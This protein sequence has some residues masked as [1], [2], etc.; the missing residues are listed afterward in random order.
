MIGRYLLI[1]CLP[2]CHLMSLYGF[3]NSMASK[4]PIALQISGS[5]WFGRPHHAFWWTKTVCDQILDKDSPIFRDRSLSLG[6]VAVNVC[7]RPP[8]K[9]TC[10]NF[11][12][13]PQNWPG[14]RDL[15]TFCLKSILWLIKKYMYI[16]QQYVRS[17]D[18]RFRDPT[19][20]NM[21]LGKNFPFQCNF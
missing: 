5:T 21:F 20:S 19:E 8:K 15:S 2:R 9:K 7:V 17:N 18:L 11:A 6:N 4:K 13:P 16:L 10:T 1:N 14:L 12:A 3:S